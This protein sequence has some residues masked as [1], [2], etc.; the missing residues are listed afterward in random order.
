MKLTTTLKIKLY[1]D[2]NTNKEFKAVTEMYSSV[3]NEVS[4]YAFETDQMKV[5]LSSLHDQVYYGIRDRLK[6]QMA[7]SVSRTVLS[8]YKTVE[9]Q[10]K[11][12]PLMIKEKGKTYTYKRD[13]GWLQK[14]IEFKKPFVDLV[15]GRDWSFVKDDD[16]VKLSINTLNKRE[17]VS[18]NHHFDDIL[19][20]KDVKLGTA[21][22][23]N[24]NGIWYLHIS[25]TKEYKDTKEVNKI[26][27]ADRGLRFVLTLFDGETTN[28]INGQDIAKTRKRFHDTRKSLQKKNTRGSRRVLKRI[29]GRENRWMND[30]NHCLSK[31]LVSEPNSLIVFEDL[32]NISFETSKGKDF[33]REL[34]SW[35]FYDLEQKTIY[36]AKMN[37]VEVIKVPARYTSQRCPLCGHIHKENRQKDKHL[38]VCRECGYTSND[39][40]IAAMNL[41]ELG[42]RYIETGK[43][44]G[45]P[46]R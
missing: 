43:I 31:A 35:A 17:V 28:F 41:Y 29:S 25:V 42:K 20:D 7:C 34:S 23:I 36:K 4:K 22:L 21:K 33:N 18:F 6:S 46:K 26:I 24:K 13:L 39:D 37:G 10:L 38:F 8:T 2:D 11:N 9:T 14:P 3:C 12:N 15:R 32:T 45:F 1:T 30:V 27:G 19:F 5:T 16:E 44:K 40:R